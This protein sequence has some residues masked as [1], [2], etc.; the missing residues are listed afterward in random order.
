[1]SLEL[2]LDDAPRE[3]PLTIYEL[4]ESARQVL[5][6]AFPAVWVEGEVSNFVRQSSGHWYFTLK[7]KQAEVRCAMFRG[8]NRRLPAEPENGLKVFARGRLT[9]YG[10]R[11][12]M[13][14]VVKDLVA[15]TEGGFHAIALERARRALEKD[16]LL[17]PARKRPL[18]P[19]PR[20][21]GMVTSPDG[22]AWRD[23]VAVIA[24]RWPM[25]ELVLVP[26]RVQGDDAP[27]DLCRALALADRYAR[28]DVLIVGRGGGS[29]ED[30]RAF[31]DEQVA[32][33]VAA[34]RVPTISAVGHET[35]VTLTDLVADVRAATPSAAAEKAVPDRLE[36]LR[37]LAS[38]EAGLG[39]AAGRRLEAAGARLAHARSRMA[40]AVTSRVRE[41]E[42]RLGQ[43]MLRMR[44]ACESRAALRRADTER[45]AASLDAL[46]PLKVLDRGY[47]VARDGAGRV[48]RRVAD[49]PSGLGFRLR[50][51]DGEVRAR[52]E[53]GT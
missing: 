27:R 30:L 44:A 4:T 22:A 46:S 21:I 2:P 14:F 31:D 35:D 53:T 37:Y 32:R 26:A 17:D 51:V 42:R 6:R 52:A 12:A 5:E 41:A 18:P 23:V 7:D 13:Q 25:V 10:A 16:G 1:M 33:A 39:T 29:K 9:V 38:L 43:A 11:G 40:G 3:R 34:S 48:L 15:T 20:V 45:L 49:F 36:L 47:S 24:R 50:V 19:F 8:D 28:L